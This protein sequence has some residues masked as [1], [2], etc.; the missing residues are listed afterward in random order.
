MPYIYELSE[1]EK[2]VLIFPAPLTDKGI[3]VEFIRFLE[4]DPGKSF[5]SLV[6]ASY[7]NGKRS[8]L[9]KYN[10]FL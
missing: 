9:K 6:E 5:C 4:A 10:S 8:I 7:R 1:D 2:K 3:E